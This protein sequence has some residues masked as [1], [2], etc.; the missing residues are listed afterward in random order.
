MTNDIN[1]C[2]K[3]KSSSIQE[4]YVDDRSMYE[5]KKCG[6]IW[7]A[8]RTTTNGPQV[9]IDEITEGVS[10][11]GEF[12]FDATILINAVFRSDTDKSQ[13]STAQLDEWA[14]KNKLHYEF[15]KTKDGNR[16]RFWR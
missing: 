10:T 13:K 12:E 15:I 11:K 9:I 16:V 7:Y 5:C 3:C 1:K 14:H 6:H 2:S 8:F 4:H